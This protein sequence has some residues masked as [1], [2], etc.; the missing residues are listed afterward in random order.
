M[1]PRERLL[2]ALRVQP[3]DRPPLWLMRQAGR[4]LPE[5]R[6]LKEQHGFLG[7]VRTPELATEVTLQPV[8]R[9]GFD[10]AILFSDILVVPEALGQGYRF[11]DEGGIAM[12]HALDSA[13]RI[14]ALRPEDL[15]ARL[16][17]VAD[18]L[19]LL[20]AELG[21]HTA[22]L[23]FAGSPWTLAAYMVEGGSSDDLRRLRSLALGEPALFGEL[24]ETLTHA[25]A[26]FLALQIESGADAVQ[27]FDTW[28]GN[29]PGEHYEAWSLR[30]IRTIVAR[31]GRRAPVIL[32][33]RGT[34]QHLAAQ[35]AC[36][37]DALSIDW[38]VDLPVTARALPAHLAVQGNLDPLLLS[39]GPDHAARAA[40]RLLARMRGRPGHVVNLGHGILPDASIA[41]VENL[42]RAVHAAGPC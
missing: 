42:V 39:L 16:A 21:G 30:W 11:R 20:R 9:F 6:A 25:V 32:F 15:R 28:G 17:Y 31:L 29:V 36:G 26:D 4:Y 35:A 23:G 10:A 24:M 22:L 8:R 3:V 18:A 41:A 1:T 5:Y 2:A 38:T 27:I 7:L 37:V 14:R 19:R 34:A 12:D 40:Q 33:A 13:E